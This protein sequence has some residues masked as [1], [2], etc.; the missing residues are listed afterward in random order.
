MMVIIKN[1]RRKCVTM[2][3]CVGYVAKVIGATTLGLLTMLSLAI[4]T[5]YFYLRTAPVTQRG[6]KGYDPR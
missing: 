6:G 4:L 2:P 3:K 5:A 1:E